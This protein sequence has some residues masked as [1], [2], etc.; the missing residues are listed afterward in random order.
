MLE[1]LKLKILRRLAPPLIRFKW[2]G[3]L[4]AGVTTQPLEIASGD[5]RVPA[6]LYK[7]EA[8]SGALPVMLYFHG[9]GWVGLNLDTHDA[10][11]RDL[12]RS[13][14]HMIISV[15]YRLA[16]EH[17][18][19][20]GVNDCLGALDWL[21]ANARRFGADPARITVGGDSAGGNLAAV[22]A[23]QARG[24]HPGVIKGQLLIYPV[25]D[26]C[27]ADWPSY[28]RYGGKPYGLTYQGMTDLWRWYTSNSPHWAP[29]ATSHDLATP[30][31]VHDLAGLPPAFVVLAEED[32]LC[33]EGVA[34]GRRMQEAGNRVQTKI[35]PEQ[36]HGFVG[37]EPSAAHSESISDMRDWLRAL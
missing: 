3:K 32:L 19:P 31:R 21:V 11:C 30:Y 2:R 37:T 5:T 22:I 25:T 17:P 28:Q 12:C 27:S 8:A 20:A 26:H 36:H 18:F 7:P 6:R 1:L 35:Y 4:P 23:Q 9:G 14:G 10:L 29:G 24:R 15:D 34:Y 16:P 33:D 13:S